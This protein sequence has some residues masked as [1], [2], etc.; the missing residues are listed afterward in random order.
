M[1]EYSNSHIYVV[2][3]VNGT[4]EAAAEKN[5]CVFFELIT[6]SELILIGQNSFS[7]M[8]PKSASDFVEILEIK[9]SP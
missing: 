6:K 7:Q 1:E 9:T 4:F 3:I 2:E 8:Y 5:G